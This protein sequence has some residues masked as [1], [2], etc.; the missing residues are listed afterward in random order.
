MAPPSTVPATAAMALGEI[1][2]D[3]EG[4]AFGVAGGSFIDPYDS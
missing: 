2:R 4:W 3:S 1:R